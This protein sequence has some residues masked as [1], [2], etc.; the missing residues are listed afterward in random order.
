MSKAAK[1][2]RQRQNRA[3]ARAHRQAAERRTRTMKTVRNFVI[4]A[5]LVALVFALM[6]VLNGGKSKK[7]TA[8]TC[9]SAK[10]A[11]PRSQT[12]PSPPPMTVDPA[13]TYTAVMGTS[14][15]KITI[16]LDAKT[17]PK[18]VNSFVFLAKSGYYDGTFFHRIV[19]NFVDQGGDQTGTG[20]GG[21]G[22]QLP[23][24]PPTNGYKSGTV[25]MANAG[26]GTTGSQFFL[27]VSDRGAST[28]GSGGPPY[29]YS[30]LG[31]ITNG[32]DIAKKINS[33]GSSDESGTPTRKIYIFKVSI[34]ESA[35]NTAGT[36][37][38]TTPS[39]P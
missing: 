15:G 27:T 39:K 24:E 13:K 2:E 34:T 37:V 25:A 33:F 31:Q 19:T 26:P 7:A 18:T 30:I 21:P 16:A 6:N 14:C 22:Y 23:D 1:R 28:L 11:A 32:L 36:S 4:V 38:S 8:I 3:A 35:Q 17:A 5:V 10:P 29:K 9:T 20:S 12:Y